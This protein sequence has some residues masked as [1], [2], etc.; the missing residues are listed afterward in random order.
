MDRFENLPTYVSREVSKSHQ[1]QRRCRRSPSRSSS[2]N[3]DISASISTCKSPLHMTLDSN[4]HPL[5]I[6]LNE[7]V[8]EEPSHRDDIFIDEKLEEIET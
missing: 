8:E 4:Y 6:Q 3:G 2:S 1:S 7:R 5:K